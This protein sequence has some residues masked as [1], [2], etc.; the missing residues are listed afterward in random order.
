[1]L[2]YATG[3]PG[4][5]FGAGELASHQAPAL[6]P[7]PLK[8]PPAALVTRISES[9]TPSI[10]LFEKLGFRVTKRVEVFGEIEMRWF[11]KQ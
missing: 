1:M 9:N 4:M 5:Y 11:H 6:V 3:A 10:R 8:V 2:R 7:S